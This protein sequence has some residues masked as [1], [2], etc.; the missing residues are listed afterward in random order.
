MARILLIHGE[1]DSK[2]DVADLLEHDRHEVL[3]AAM[4]DH[5]LTLALQI[6]PDL[7]IVCPSH[8]VPRGFEI[9]TRLTRRLP[10]LA[11]IVVAPDSQ[12]RVA[13][14]A[15][16]AGADDYLTQPFD[17]QELSCAIERVLKAP[18]A[19]PG[20]RDIGSRRRSAG[21]DATALLVGTS[22]VISELRRIVARVGPSPATV[23][24]LGES[25]TGKELVARGI[26]QSSARRDGPFVPVNCSAIP[27]TLVEAEFFG[28]E[29]GA[30]TDAKDAHA[31]KFEQAHGG[32]LFLDEVADLAQDAQ[33]KLLRVLQDQQVTR[34]GGRRPRQVDVRLVA[35]TN[36]HLEQAVTDGAFREDLFWRLNV[37]TLR[38]PPLR[39]RREDLSALIDTFLSR[40]DREFGCAAATIA[41]EALALLM[42]Y[43]WPGNV[44]ELENTLRGAL[45][46]SDGPIVRVR[47]LPPRIRSEAER[48]ERACHEASGPQRPFTLSETVRTIVQRVERRVIEDTL[49][50][51]HGNRTA[52]AESLG[53]NRKT[54]FNKLRT[55][56]F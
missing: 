40:L 27:S 4:D 9:V 35:A 29:R 48:D 50:A 13:V 28:F 18:R 45:I 54:L 2:T 17:R 3:R 10:A 7:A 20:P 34:L 30:F 21:D 44:R 8:P 55:H 47:D 22:P 38:V 49:A 31:G 23:L 51:H 33:A 26:H 15:I 19:T 39:E 24:V 5:A 36:K 11:C 56:G 32:T 14:A 43:D 52:A 6:R 46:L 41:P 12:V 37:L 1:H 16:R 53:I 42:A 25:G